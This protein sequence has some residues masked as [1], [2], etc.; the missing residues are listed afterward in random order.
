MFKHRRRGAKKEQESRST[1]SGGIAGSEAKVDEYIPPLPWIDSTSLFWGMMS[2]SRAPDP[3]MFP[4]LRYLRMQTSF[5]LGALS[6]N[7][8]FPPDHPFSR[9]A[10]D[11]ASDIRAQ[12]DVFVASADVGMRKPAREIYELTVQRLDE[13]DKRR[14]GSGIG[15]RDVLFLDDIGQNVKMARSLGMRTIKVVLGETEEAVRSLGREIGIDLLAETRR[16]GGKAKL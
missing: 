7:I 11:P 15:P 6:N 16:E 14:G 5:L 12:F 3:F 4:A 8:T 10:S 2:I 1:D 13:F 9:P